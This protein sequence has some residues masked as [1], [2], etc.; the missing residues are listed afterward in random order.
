MAKHGATPLDQTN[1]C[2]FEVTVSLGR[3]PITNRLIIPLE[4]EG[5][6]LAATGGREAAPELQHTRGGNTLP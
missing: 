6:D 2:P 1:P 4:K 5:F 3:W